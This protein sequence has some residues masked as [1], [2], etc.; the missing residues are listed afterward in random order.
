MPVPSTLSYKN[1]K[2]HLPLV[3]TLLVL[4][5][6]YTQLPFIGLYSHSI[7]CTLTDTINTSIVSMVQPSTVLPLPCAKG[8]QKT[9]QFKGRIVSLA[10]TQAGWERSVRSACACFRSPPRISTH[11]T[12]YSGYELCRAG[13]ANH[14]A[15]IRLEVPDGTTSGS[16]SPDLY[17]LV[18]RPFKEHHKKANKN[19]C[20]P[21]G[22]HKHN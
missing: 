16:R 13:G 18:S 10:T 8:F 22:S 21:D 15:V 6:G 14:T 11:T 20:S 3:S 12:M 17:V 1:I 7:Y 4:Y 9:M 2:Y 19:H 5:R